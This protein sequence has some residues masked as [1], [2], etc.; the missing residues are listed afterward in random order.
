M[1]PLGRARLLVAA[2][3]PEHH[4]HNPRKE[5]MSD[6]KLSIVGV[7]SEI[8]EKNGWTNFAV[9]APGKQYPVK[10]STKKEELI[11]QARAVGDGVATWSYVERES[12]SVNP[13]NNQP[14][15]NRWLEGVE[16]GEQRTEQPAPTAG[17]SPAGQTSTYEGLAYG[18]KERSIIRQTCIKAACWL[19]SGQGVFPDQDPNENIDWPLGVMQAAD[20][21]ERWIVRDLAEPP[22]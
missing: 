17:G 8:S 7:C 10:L 6:D 20:R 3:A 15:V 9:L 1:T 12:D 4:D 13:H 2:R 19:Y 14:Y 16:A 5:E 18:D 11:A 21:F 22:F